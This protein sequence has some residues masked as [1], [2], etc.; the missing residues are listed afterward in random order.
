MFRSRGENL[1]SVYILLFLN[2]AFFFLQ[3]QDG[4][5]FAR[6]FT[7]DWSAVLQGEAWR[8]FTYQFVQASRIGTIAIP[9]VI[10][11]FLNLVLLS[12]MGMAVEDA[13]GTRH[14]LT[15]FVLSTLGSAA[16][17]AY[18]GV[19]LLG[20]YF[21]NFTLLFVYA[22]L[23]RDQTFYLS[24]AIPVRVTFLALLA[25]GALLVGVFFGNASNIAALAGAAAAF[26]YY[27]TQRVRR[28]P[29]AAPPGFA[30]AT[31][32][33][34]PLALVTR[35]ITRVAAMKKALSTRSDSDIDRLIGISEK[36]I[37]AG[38]NICAP[39]DFKP[40]HPDRYCIRCDGFAE[41]TARH[42]RLN[43]PTTATG[44]D[45]LATAP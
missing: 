43:R 33:V 28:A 15:L 4:E 3:H 40:E 26:V 20:S 7:L 38:V 31:D 12:L 18:L 23:N 30:P 9:P 11:L 32:D 8:V 19:P 36:E 5:K 13:W 27:L 29:A 24:T 45:D 35:H 22:A 21:I 14:F 6:L 37:V 16:A 44:S 42:L 25:L 41:C 34:D 1:R 2:V 17:A 39:V 10:T